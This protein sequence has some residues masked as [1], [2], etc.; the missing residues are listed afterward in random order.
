[1][2]GPQA[3]STLATGDIPDNPRKVALEFLQALGFAVVGG[4][5]RPADALKIKAIADQPGIHPEVRAEL[6]KIAQGG[7]DYGWQ[8]GAEATKAPGQ[9]ARQGFLR[10][11]HRIAGGGPGTSEAPVGRHETL[12]PVAGSSSP[13]PGSDD[14]YRAVAAKRLRPREGAE[15]VV[16][17][18]REPSE[19]LGTAVPGRAGPPDARDTARPTPRDFAGESDQE[20]RLLTAGHPTTRT[21]DQVR[22]L[23]GRARWEGAEEHIQQ[24]YGSSGQRHFSVPTGTTR[25]TTSRSGGR[26]VDAAFDTTDG[27]VLADEVKMYQQWRMILGG[28]RKTPV[29]LTRQIREQILKDVWLRNNT[30]GFDPRWLFLDSPPSEKLSKFLKHYNIVFVIYR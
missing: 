26:Y 16:G 4:R 6:N 18:S 13:E 1:M 20:R 30:P 7:A 23:R 11:I 21:L 25:R 2:L 8:E 14:F 19:G 12:P 9:P 15:G 10:G 5:M 3:V 17:T 24:M 28:L 22:A 29:P 27:G